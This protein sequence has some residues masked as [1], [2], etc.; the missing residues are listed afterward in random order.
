MNRNEKKFNRSI[1]CDQLYCN[2][3]IAKDIASTSYPP[4]NAD[5]VTLAASASLP[6]ER[7][8]TAGTAITIVDSGPGNPVTINSTGS[9]VTLSSA[10]G[11]NSLVV[12]GVGPTLSNKGL[13][14]GTAISI[15]DGG[16]FLTIN[17]LGDN[18]TLSSAGGVNSLVVD[19][20][21]PTLSN[22]GLT[23]GT[24][25]SIVDGGTFLT[26]NS[27]GTNVT[28]SSA[29]GVNSLVVD[30]AG[31]TLSTK[32]LTAGTAISIVDGGN[33]LTINSDGTNVTLTN[34]GAGATLVN[35][36]TGPTLAIKSITGT[37][38]IAVTNA[39]TNIDL[40]LPTGSLS[41]PVL[42]Y[43][44]GT[45]AEETKLQVNSATGEVYNSAGILTLGNLGDT[46][47]RTI[48]LETDT[49][50][51][52]DIVFNLAGTNLWRLRSNGTTE[53][54]TLREIK[55]GFTVLS[56]NTNVGGATI[57]F[58]GTSGI[59]QRTTGNTSNGAFA[60]GT[61]GILSGDATYRG[62]S[63]GQVVDA[64]KQYGLLA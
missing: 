36:G 45:W 59:V 35:D 32:G 41:G 12:D 50:G 6:N 38:G 2:R 39:A 64:L 17:S 8:L 63:V 49:G 58:L 28:L 54:F 1:E 18:V 21:G 16:T 24:A 44:A 3:L 9:N 11:V 31:P 37:R 33:F 43:N 22:K 26:I 48:L 40:A 7:I 51:N 20:V 29:G 25:I 15:V 30:G 10:G 61:S 52:E 56:S 57:G 14:A 34:A 55:N 13:T 53:E 19:G 46:N 4:L 42:T 5:Y 47:D 27:D 60:S 23:A 62:Y